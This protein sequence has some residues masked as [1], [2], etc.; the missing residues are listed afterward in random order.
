MLALI[1]YLSRW[2]EASLSVSTTPNILT[3]IILVQIIPRYGTVENTDSDQRSHSTSRIL[4]KLMETL[5][6]R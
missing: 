4:Q 1:D 6:I 2:V 3:K 5:G